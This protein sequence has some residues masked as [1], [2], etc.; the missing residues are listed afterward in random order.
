MRMKRE[1]VKRNKK[2]E[3]IVKTEQKGELYDNDSSLTG[4]I[5]ATLQCLFFLHF[6]RLHMFRT[7]CSFCS[8]SLST[9]LVLTPVFFLFVLIASLVYVYINILPF[10]Y[11]YKR[12][13]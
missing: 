4:G 6:I 11:Y 1:Y 5:Y 10:A 3:G 13:C 12:N 9:S 7:K 8:F 2:K